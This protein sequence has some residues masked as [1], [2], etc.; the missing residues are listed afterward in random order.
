MNK[1]DALRWAA[2]ELSE[3]A[4]QLAEDYLSSEVT[5]PLHED[6]EKPGD[7]QR[8]IDAFTELHERMNVISIGR[9]KLSE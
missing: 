6:E 7:R 4:A 2:S 8:V 9:R 5:L 3:Y 1:R